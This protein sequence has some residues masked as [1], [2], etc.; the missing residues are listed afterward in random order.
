MDTEIFSENPKYAENIPQ[1]PGH[2]SLQ[3]RIYS[4]YGGAILEYASAFYMV[5]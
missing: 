1:K 4:D 2:F 3:N 5:I